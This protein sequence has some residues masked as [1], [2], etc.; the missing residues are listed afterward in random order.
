MQPYGVPQAYDVGLRNDWADILRADQLVH[1]CLLGAIIAGTFQGWLKDRIAG[2][3]PY[4]L[5]DGLY[6]GAILLWFATLAVQ[7]RPLFVL[8]ASSRIDVV[9]LMLVCIPVP[10]FLTFA[11]A[12]PIQAA[13][14]RA[15]SAFPIAAIMGLSITRSAGQ[16][17]AYVGVILLLCAVTGIYGILQYRAGPQV[18]LASELSQVRHGETLHYLTRLGTPS[19]RAFSTFTFPAP[20]AAMMSFGMLLAA[21]LVASRASSLSVR[22]AAL[23][24]APLLFV[25]MTLSGTRATLVTLL[26]GLLVIGWLRGSRGWQLLLLAA[27]VAALHFATVY[28]A[29]NI[30]DRF[31]SLLADEQLAWTY[32]AR[33][34]RT[35]FAALLEHPLGQGLGRSGVGVPY[36]AA[37]AMPP[38]YFVFCDGDTCRAAVELGV[39][40]VLWLVFALVGLLPEVYRAARYLSGTELAD[41][42]LGIGA[43]LLSSALVL[44]VGSPLSSTPHALIW[45]FLVGALLRLAWLERDA[46]LARDA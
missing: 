3:L 14:L 30:L 18:A 31:R 9:L 13:G 46:A 38:D 28:T 22:T 27:L 10:F 26:A 33:P 32:V 12:L 1:V 7:R 37:M 29:G 16:V 8:P 2:P 41:L 39:L 25:A 4:L 6:G 43:L 40:G 35:G 21:G 19:F 36:T 44:L 5:S 34:L 11:T 23:V 20:F 45:W 15:W 42:G 17:R 24:L